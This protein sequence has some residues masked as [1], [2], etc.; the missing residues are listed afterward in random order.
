MKKAECENCG[1]EIAPLKSKPYL[2]SECR[3]DEGGTK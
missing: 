2:C 3:K 1:K